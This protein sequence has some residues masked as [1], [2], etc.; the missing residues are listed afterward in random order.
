MEWPT[1]EEYAINIIVLYSRQFNVLLILHA[2]QAASR[3][4]CDFRL[5]TSRTQALQY[6]R[7][8]TRQQSRQ[9]FSVVYYF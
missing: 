5:I 7:V 1:A 4:T 2:A 3:C 9:Q 6:T 8:N